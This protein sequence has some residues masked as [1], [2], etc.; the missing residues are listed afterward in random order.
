MTPA[1]R[2]RAHGSGSVTQRKDG[3][4][5]GRYEA[6]SSPTGARR[7]RTVTGRTKAEAERRLKEARRAADGLSGQN[8]P[9]MLAAGAIK[10]RPGYVHTLEMVDGR[11]IVYVSRTRPEDS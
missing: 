5:I 4:W 11:P 2:R 3:Y 6:G 8:D 10:P 9:L 7:R 1:K